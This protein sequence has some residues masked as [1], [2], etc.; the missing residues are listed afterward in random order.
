MFW[1][2]VTYD[3]D[4]KSSA[5][6]L[7]H[8]TFNHLARSLEC[9][10]AVRFRKSCLELTFVCTICLFF[11]HSTSTMAAPPP[12]SSRPTGLNDGFLES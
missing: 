7:Q 11:Y 4:C 1:S 9:K 3:G 5:L 8:R 2:Q 6:A 10:G 12:A